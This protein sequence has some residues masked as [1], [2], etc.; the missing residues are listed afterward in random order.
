[1]AP[2]Y[3]NRDSINVGPFTIKTDSPPVYWGSGTK[4]KSSGQPW[5]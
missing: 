1:M 3:R 5:R 2:P 4:N